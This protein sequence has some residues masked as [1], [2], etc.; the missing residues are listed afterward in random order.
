[1]PTD[2]FIYPNTH[3]LQQLRYNLASPCIL[4]VPARHGKKDVA[5]A[6]EA[7]N[8]IHHNALQRISKAGELTL[9]FRFIHFTLYIYKEMVFM[10]RLKP[11]YPRSRFPF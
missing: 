10:L 1:M 7:G 5:L 8:S 3:L 4:A 6:W 2:L 9:Y 11:S